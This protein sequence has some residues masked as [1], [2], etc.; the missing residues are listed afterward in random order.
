MEGL[1]R[2]SQATCSAAHGS[3]YGHATLASNRNVHRDAEAAEGSANCGVLKN[4]HKPGMK[5]IATCTHD[6]MSD[7]HCNANIANTHTHTDARTHTHTHTYT[8][9]TA[10]THTISGAN[11][12]EQAISNWHTVRPLECSL[13]SAKFEAKKL[14]TVHSCHDS[15]GCCG[16]RCLH[17]CHDRRSCHKNW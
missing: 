15:S 4:S 14:A 13:R 6:C 3:K 17:R 10:H 11:I 7:F 5:P 12:Y 9:T 2:T 8:H 1:A 16:C